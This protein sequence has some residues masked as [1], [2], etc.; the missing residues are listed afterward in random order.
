VQEAKTHLSALLAEVEQGA[1]I[2]IARGTIPVARLVPVDVA[3]ERDMGFVSYR[4]P[5]SF[6]DQLPATEL[7]AWE[8]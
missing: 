7:E 2:T 3:R 4:V 6:F 1:E 5:D 8:G